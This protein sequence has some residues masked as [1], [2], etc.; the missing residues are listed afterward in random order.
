L[1]AANLKLKPGKCNFAKSDV[2]YLGHIISGQGVSVNPEKVEVVKS[3][4]LLKNQHD[5][6]AFLSLTNYY[7]KHVRNYAKIASPLNKLLSKDIPFKRT[8]NCDKAFQLLK[9]MLAS[10]PILAFPDMTNPL[11]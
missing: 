11:Y 5:V 2:L 10:A 4:P 8:E 1:R 3:I 6:R 9:D 7:R